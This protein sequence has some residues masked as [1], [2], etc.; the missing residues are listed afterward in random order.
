MTESTFQPGI[1]DLI[2]KLNEQERLTI[3]MVTHDQAIA[4]EAHRTVKLCEGRIE[5]LTDAA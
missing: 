2:A 4:A 1:I 3:I 5:A